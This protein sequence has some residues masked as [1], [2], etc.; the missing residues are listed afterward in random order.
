MPHDS[1]DEII[2][3]N[4]SATSFDNE[5]SYL[6][7]QKDQNWKYNTIRYEGKVIVLGEWTSRTKSHRHVVIGPDW[8]CVILTFVVITA[9]SVLVYLHIIHNWIEMAV[10]LILLAV[11]MFGLTAVVV[12]DP[13]LVRRYHHARTRQWTFCDHCESFR[14]PG[15]V[16]CSTC[17]VCVAG[18]DHHCPVRCNDSYTAHYIFAYA[19]LL[20]C[21]Q[22]TGKCVGA[23]N[24]LYFKIFVIALS[25]LV[26]LSVALAVLDAF[27]IGFW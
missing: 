11:V 6:V 12:A 24:V 19:F 7:K 21:S 1:A 4:S 20:F 25:W 23:G 22:W 15:S 27:E 13:G 26:L 3:D 5:E 10:F 17:Q 2:S 9:F 16:H 18:Y 8:P 14:P